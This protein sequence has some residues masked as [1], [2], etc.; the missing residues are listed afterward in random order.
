MGRVKSGQGQ[1]EPGS[2]LVVI[3]HYRGT[4]ATLRCM[5]AVQRQ[6][7][8]EGQ[9]IDG[10]MGDS[11][12]E[13]RGGRWEGVVVNNGYPDRERAGEE[14]WSVVEQRARSLGW[15]VIDAGSNTGF[16]GGSNLGITRA[17]EQGFE[18][19]WLINPDAIAE[20]GAL[21]ALV[22]TAAR[23]ERLGAVGSDLGGGPPGGRVSLWRGKAI[24]AD[25]GPWE[26]VSGASMLLRVAAIS[27]VGGF[28]EKLFLYWEDVELCIRL[29]EKGWRLAV[30]RGSRVRHEGGGAVG[31][32]SPTQD[33]YSARNGLLVVRKH[34]SWSMAVAV[35]FV[36]ARVTVAK[37][38]RGEWRRLTA[39]WRGLIDGVLGRGGQRPND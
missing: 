37:L 38:V 17:V 23:D 22:E 11:R 35:V 33:Y 15:G 26:F 30:E 1:V 4:G 18:F 34:A 8:S 21:R 2:V 14:S 29:R 19:V 3:V 32:A 5:E 24:E 31:K 28:D 9:I 6:K 10:Q 36:T 12:G 13:G 25:A 20:T 7:M 16:A 27:E 39:A